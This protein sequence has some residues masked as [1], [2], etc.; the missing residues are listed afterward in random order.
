MALLTFANPI[1]AANAMTASSNVIA[2]ACKMQ[3]RK[4]PVWD[5]GVC[6]IA[7]TRKTVYNWVYDEAI[8][9]GVRRKTRWAIN[10]A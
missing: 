3:K 6:V 8:L 5:L 2:H 4:G 7:E 10:F 1:L 9:P